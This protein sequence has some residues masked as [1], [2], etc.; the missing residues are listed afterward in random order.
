MALGKVRVPRTGM[1]QLQPSR[2]YAASPF[3]PYSGMF[4]G[5]ENLQSRMLQEQMAKAIVSPFQINDPNVIRAIRGVHGITD[6]RNY[7]VGRQ[8]GGALGAVAGTALATY[9]YVPAIIGLIKGTYVTAAGTS[10][11]G[12]GVPIGVA[13]ASLATIAT[14][15]SGYQIGKTIG[16]AAST[17]G[18][19]AWGTY[20]SNLGNSLVRRPITTVL[21]VAGTIGTAYAVS[22]IPGISRIPGAT[23][24]T[25]MY[26]NQYLNKFGNYIDGQIFVK[27]S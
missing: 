6:T 5:E 8:V 17:E 3:R 13:L 11:T 2:L 21:N 10:V 18:Q 25:T 14:I 27:L 15:I 23:T 19:K 4:P 24:I 16:A 12:I 20:L 1:V 26:A 9:S 22:K 7:E